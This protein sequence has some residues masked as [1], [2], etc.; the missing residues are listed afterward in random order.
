MNVVCHMAVDNPRA[1]II[2]PHIR[3]CHTSRQKFYHIGAVPTVQQCVAL[4]VGRVQIEFIAHSEYKPSNL[5]ARTRSPDREGFRKSN[6]LLHAEAT[7]PF[8]VLVEI[9][10]EVIH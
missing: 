9:C 1:G 4:P 3:S 2:G 10:W 8:L 5:V 7:P 6:R